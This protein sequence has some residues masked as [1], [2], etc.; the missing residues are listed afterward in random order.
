[1]SVASQSQVTHHHSSKSSLSKFRALLHCVLL[2]SLWTLGMLEEGRVVTTPRGRGRVLKQVGN[3]ARV[4]YDGGSTN[5]VEVKDIL[6]D[7]GER[8]QMSD[9]AQAAKLEFRSFFERYGLS[10]DSDTHRAGIRSDLLQ[11]LNEAAISN[12]SCGSNANT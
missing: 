12:T 2:S 9:E 11:S 7:G 6:D 10:T 8:G 5:W 3:R 4:E 1:M